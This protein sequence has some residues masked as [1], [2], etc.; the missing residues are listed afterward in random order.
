MNKKFGNSV[1]FKQFYG[2]LNTIYKLIRWN[3]NRVNCQVRNHER[4]DGNYVKLR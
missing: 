1:L 2:S 4:R 3:I